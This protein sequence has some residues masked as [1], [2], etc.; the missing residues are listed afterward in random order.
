MGQLTLLLSICMVN[1]LLL[2]VR[3]TPNTIFCMCN[4]WV[5]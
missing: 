2:K 4:I 3:L 5:I 1:Q